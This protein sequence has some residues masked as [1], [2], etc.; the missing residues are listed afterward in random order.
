MRVSVKVCATR[1]LRAKTTLVQSL[2][3]LPFGRRHAT[4]GTFRS[5]GEG[6]EL[7]QSRILTLVEYTDGTT[8]F[9]RTE[10]VA[11]SH[12]KHQLYAMSEL[13]L[14]RLYWANFNNLA[15]SDSRAR[16][17][18]KIHCC[19]SLLTN[20]GYGRLQSL[21]PSGYPRS[22]PTTHFVPLMPPSPKPSSETARVYCSFWAASC[23]PACHRS[24][25][26][27]HARG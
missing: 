19:F 17:C 18:S 2:S 22:S 20:L 23:L 8:I 1:I 5:R 4:S 15:S 25:T 14:T 3:L 16:T 27:T 24:Y 13:L 26:S 21:E 6:L 9:L 7:F 11:V 12:M 10:C